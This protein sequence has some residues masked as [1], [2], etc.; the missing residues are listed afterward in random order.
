MSMPDREGFLR[1]N[2]IFI[3]KIVLHVQACGVEK[4]V[5]FGNGWGQ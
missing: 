4:G 3:T 1:V 5:G 2:V